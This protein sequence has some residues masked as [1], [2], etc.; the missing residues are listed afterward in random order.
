MDSII[1][2]HSFRNRPKIF[3][4]LF[5]WNFPPYI[6]NFPN[7]N[8]NNAKDTVLICSTSHII[9][10][11]YSM[12]AP[13]VNIISKG[14]KLNWLTG[15]SNSTLNKP[16][17]CK[18][19]HFIIDIDRFI[20]HIH[21]IAMRNNLYSSNFK[22]TSLATFT[23]HRFKFQGQLQTAQFLDNYYGWLGWV[24]IMWMCSVN[25][26]ENDHFRWS[27]IVKILF[28]SFSI[29]TKMDN[30]WSIRLIKML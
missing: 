20:I 2:K 6:S 5:S 17:V 14:I 1:T 28:Q 11:F 13:F 16:I 29:F 30:K 18:P 15:N 27:F 3:V 10:E 26:I 19:V 9:G 8:N 7:E 24:W 4:C 21:Q 12:R 23:F 25:S 22:H